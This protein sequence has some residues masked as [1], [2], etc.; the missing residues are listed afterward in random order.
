MFYD[1]FYDKIY[2]L[3]NVLRLFTNPE[4]KIYPSVSLVPSLR[5]QSSLHD[6]PS[7]SPYVSPSLSPFHLPPT[8]PVTLSPSRVPTPPLPN[9]VPLDTTTP[10]FSP[11]LVTCYS[12]SMILDD[13]TFEISPSTVPYT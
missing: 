13:V 2:G 12:T 8:L 9:L 10:G 3:Y 11:P 1:K 7:F 6:S 4:S 5:R